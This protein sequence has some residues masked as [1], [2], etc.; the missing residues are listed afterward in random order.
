METTDAAER[1]A[2]LEVRAQ[3]DAFPLPEPQPFKVALGTSFHRALPRL[4]SARFLVVGRCTPRRSRA[5][6]PDSERRDT[7]GTTS[8]ARPASGDSPET[9]T[10]ASRSRSVDR[11]SLFLGP[12]SRGSV[13]RRGLAEGSAPPHEK[14]PP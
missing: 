3:V 9:P 2:I 4:E 12:I 11:S 14:G 13:F 8:S 5:T 7:A 10:S 1:R 6:L